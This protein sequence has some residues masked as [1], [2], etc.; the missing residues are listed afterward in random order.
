MKA[1]IG[2]KLVVVATHAGEPA[3]DGRIL[4]VQGADGAPP[5]LVEWSDNGHRGLV[6]PGP[7]A[8]VKHYG[9]EVAP[10]P[11]DGRRA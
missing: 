1:A 3:R 10:G 4:E 8:H 11:A 6:F 7:N 9:H 2:D 5:Y